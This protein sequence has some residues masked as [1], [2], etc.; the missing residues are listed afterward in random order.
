MGLTFEERKVEIVQYPQPHEKFKSL[1]F[2]LLFSHSNRKASHLEYIS[3]SLSQGVLAKIKC[4]INYHVFNLHIEIFRVVPSSNRFHMHDNNEF[5]GIGK[6]FL[7]FVL[8]HLLKTHYICRF[9][10]VT[11]VASGSPH[12]VEKYNRQQKIIKDEEMDLLIKFY[13]GDDESFASTRTHEEV[14]NEILQCHGLV[15][16]YKKL[17]FEE[18][19]EFMKAP[20]GVA[21]KSKVET[22]LNSLQK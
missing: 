2:N 14:C 18:E 9:F 4:A 15:T 7:K 12:D 3:K 22:I 6:R 1:E 19:Y 16:Y 5:K 13:G 21:M 20:D 17:G 10:K 11:L 8:E